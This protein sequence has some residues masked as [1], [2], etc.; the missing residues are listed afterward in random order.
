MEFFETPN[1]LCPYVDR[2][3]CINFSTQTGK[4]RPSEYREILHFL[5]LLSFPFLSLRILFSYPFFFLFF[6][7]FSFFL[8]LLP[9]VFFLVPISFHFSPHSFLLI[10]S[11]LLEIS[12]LFGSILTIQSREEISSPFPSSHLC[13]ALFSPL[14]PYF[15]I[16]FLLHHPSCS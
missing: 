14:F 9:N 15:F 13:G 12:L 1:F 8:F 10:Y 6:F 11:F 16:S 3:A 5:S 2:V 4:L 7:C